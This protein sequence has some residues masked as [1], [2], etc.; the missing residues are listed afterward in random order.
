MSEADREARGPRRSLPATVLFMALLLGLLV[1]RMGVLG[2]PEVSPPE[3][4]M[5][6]VPVVSSTRAPREGYLSPPFDARTLKGRRVELEELRGSP[7]FMNFWAPWCGPCRA[8]MEAIGR[9]A[10]ESPGDVHVLAIAVDS[11]EEDV[12]RFVQKNGVSFPVIYDDDG[13]LGAR[14]E[15]AGLPTTIILDPRGFVVKRIVGAR[16][17]DHP[18]FSAWVAKLA[19]TDGG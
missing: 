14:F 10:D 12:Q 13:S 2:P 9:L 1:W 19:S 4:L 6:P 15:I 16:A 18:D 17:W 8:E 7:V 11:R 3:D 5:V